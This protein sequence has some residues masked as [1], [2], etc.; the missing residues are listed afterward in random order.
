M[1]GLGL[2]PCGLSEREPVA[3]ACVYVVTICGGVVDAGGPSAA[4]EAAAAVGVE[5]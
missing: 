1:T 2:C 3:G 4:A 5:F